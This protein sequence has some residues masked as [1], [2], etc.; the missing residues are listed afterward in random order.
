MEKSTYQEA[1]KNAVA[2]VEIEGYHI[3]ERQKELSLD[4]LSG[5]IDKSEFINLLLKGCNV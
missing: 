1:F 2:S 4:F 3:S 5:K